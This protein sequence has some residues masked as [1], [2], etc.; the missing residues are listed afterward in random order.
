MLSYQKKLQNDL[1]DFKTE[2][3]PRNEKFVMASLIILLRDMKDS[4]GNF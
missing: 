1:A 3:L 2:E 4:K